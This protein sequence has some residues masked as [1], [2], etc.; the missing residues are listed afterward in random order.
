LWGGKEKER[1]KGKLKRIPRGD[2][3]TFPFC[4]AKI[5]KML[6]IAK[7]FSV[8]LG[9]IGKSANHLSPLSLSLSDSI[10]EIK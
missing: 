10:T 1:N 6:E 5:L 8:R 7:Q 4:S 2:R 9:D 3:K